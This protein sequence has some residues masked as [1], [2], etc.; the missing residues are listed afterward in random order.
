MADG[1]YYLIMP[2][3]LMAKNKYF[4][5]VM[6]K[7]RFFLAIDYHHPFISLDHNFYHRS[8]TG[9]W[10]LDP[11]EVTS[12]LFENVDKICRNKYILLYQTEL[13]TT[14]ALATWKI[15]QYFLYLTNLY[16]TANVLSVQM[17][18][19]C[20]TARSVYIFWPQFPQQYISLAYIQNVKKIQFINSK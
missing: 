10:K 3:T 20:I 15:Y 19:G 5:A 14:L 2:Y 6:P 13:G 9:L 16:E 7:I 18:L 1:I 8:T 4:Y 12:S 17:L 11:G